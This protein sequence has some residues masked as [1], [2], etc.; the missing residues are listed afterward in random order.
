[1]ND[2]LDAFAL[3]FFFNVNDKEKLGGLTGLYFN[4]FNNYILIEHFP[5]NVTFMYRIMRL[6]LLVIPVEQVDDPLLLVIV[7]SLHGK[8]F[9]LFLRF[10]C[11]IT[12]THHTPCGS[13]QH[14]S[15]TCLMLVTS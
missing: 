6:L 7:Q 3:H 10:N 11:L 9:D 8:R 5:M 13:T 4:E 14:T 12:S 15:S 2:F 1:M